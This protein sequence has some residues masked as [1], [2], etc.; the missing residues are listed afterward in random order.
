MPI[1]IAEKLSVEEDKCLINISTLDSSYPQFCKNAIKLRCLINRIFN[2]ERKV[3]AQ[4]R[5][6][7]TFAISKPTSYSTTKLDLSPFALFAG[8]PQGYYIEIL[9]INFLY[10]YKGAD[11]EFPIFPGEILTS[12]S[13]YQIKAVVQEDI[14]T[15]KK[16]GFAFETIGLL[17]QSKLEAIASDLREGLLR[18]EKNDPEGSIKFFRKVVEGFKIYIKDKTIHSVNRT[19]RLSRFFGAAFDLASNFG[20]HAGTHGWT[21]EAIFCRDLSVA[22]SRY[23]VR[24]LK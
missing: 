15:L 19:D 12:A 14:E 3:T 5:E 7:Q 16:V 22:I 13:D 6:I 17:Y 20:E 24:T 4:P 8:I 23:M 21:D 10:S 18:I 9:A 11:Y 1:V 2:A